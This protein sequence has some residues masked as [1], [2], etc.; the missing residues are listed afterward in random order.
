VSGCVCLGVCVW[1]C[2]C[3]CVSVC[4]C[5]CLG[6]CV[7]VCVCVCVSG[8]VCGESRLL[9]LHCPQKTGFLPPVH[10]EVP[11]PH[12]YFPSTYLS[13]GNCHN[14]WH[15]VQGVNT[16]N[17]CS[18]SDS[19]QPTSPSIHSNYSRFLWSKSKNSAFTFKYLLMK[20]SSWT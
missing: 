9:M 19:I 5:F 10:F 17:S 15:N 13:R 18:V 16:K 2:A 1:V 6:V 4:V 8:C 3:G 11:S 14:F 7:W 20:L 12:N